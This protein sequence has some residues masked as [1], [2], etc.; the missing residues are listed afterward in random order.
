MESILKTR[1]AELEGR[2][3]KDSPLKG[4]IELSDY[5][6]KKYRKQYLR[7]LKSP[8]LKYKPPPKIKGKRGRKKQADYKNLLDR[9]FEH[10][11]D[12]L[13]FMYD[14]RIPFDNNISERALRMVKVKMKVSGC[15]RSEKGAQS[16]CRIKTYLATA[17]K[18]GR[19]LL[20]ALKY[21]FSTNVRLK[22]IFE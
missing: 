10:P 14:F 18:N 19:N 11:D 15:F 20:E 4:N 5:R 6:L 7:I 12:V 2:N 16:F 13:R 8:R 3:N 9:L 21:S 22:E 17:R 1:I